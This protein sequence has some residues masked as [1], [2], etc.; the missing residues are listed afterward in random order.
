MDIVQP[1]S[2]LQEQGRRGF[3]RGECDLDRRQNFNGSMVYETPQFSNS[4]LRILGGGWRISGIVRLLSGGTLCSGSGGTC[5]SAGLDQALTG[6]TDQR[7]NQILPDPY[8]PN[9]GVK[10]WVNPAAFAQAPLGTYG[11]SP[12]TL[13]GPGSIRIDMGVTRTFRVREKESVE[14]RA[15]AF[16][17]PNHMNPGNPS[18]TLTDQNFGRILS[19]GDPRIMQF[20][21]KFVF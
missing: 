10:L 13:A 21:L 5:L 4:T 2:R 6:M 12:L 3:N 20:A 8:A 17:L 15:E 11:T 16:N 7:P 14:F 9:K 1:N 19:A 18:A